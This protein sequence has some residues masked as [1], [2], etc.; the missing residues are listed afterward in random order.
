MDNGA[1]PRGALGAG[2][3]ISASLEQQILPTALQFMTM[4]TWKLRSASSDHSDT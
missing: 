3:I 1:A 2:G 4:T